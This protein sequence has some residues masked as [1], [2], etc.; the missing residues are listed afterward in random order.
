[1]KKFDLIIANPPYGSIG[2]AITQSIIDNIDFGEFVNLLPATNY[3]LSKTNLQKHVDPAE[4][5]VVYNAFEDAA[6]LPTVG[7]VYKEEINDLTPMGFRIETQTD[8]TTK[9]YF[10]ANVKRDVTYADM[11][12]TN[13]MA[14]TDGDLSKSIYLPMRLTNDAVGG[15]CG[16][17]SIGPSKKTASYKTALGLISNTS[18]MLHGTPNLGTYVRFS[19]EDEKKNCGEFLFGDGF[20][21][22]LWLLNSMRVDVAHKAEH[23]FW[24]P[25]VDWHRK[26]TPREILEDYGYSEEEIAQVEEKMAEYPDLKE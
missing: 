15:H 23:E 1:M 17:A 12:E 3:R 16:L 22:V 6:V 14:A 19:T 18:E 26:W 9:K 5:T 7:H 10:L 24:L 13:A 4:I 21:F 25:R 20:K 11:L 8:P 2:S